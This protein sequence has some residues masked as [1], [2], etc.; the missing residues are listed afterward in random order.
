MTRSLFYTLLAVLVLA[1]PLAAC[2]SGST[3]TPDG[4]TDAADGD[5]IDGDAVDG[6]ET[7]GDLVDG[8]KPDGDVVDGDEDGDVD[9]D[10]VDGDQESEPDPDIDLGLF[11][12]ENAESELANQA[13]KRAFERNPDDPNARFGYAFSEAMVG[14]DTLF[15]LL[16][17]VE[18]QINK[19]DTKASKEGEDGEY[20]D[21]GDW[22]DKELRHA[23]VLI[24][25][26]FNRASDLYQP[27]LE[28]GGVSLHVDHLPVT[29]GVDEGTW[30]TGEIDDADVF[31][32]DGMARTMAVLFEFIA[33]H[34]IH[35]DLYG[36]VSIVK[37]QVQGESDFMSI[38]GVV[39]YLLQFDER[40]LALTEDG[41]EV[42]ARTR[43]L[44]LG[45]LNDIILAAG[46]AEAELVVDEDQSDEIFSVVTERGGVKKLVLNVSRID[47]ATGEPI[48]NAIE[49][50]TP[51]VV[52]AAA[53][54]RTHITDGGGPLSFDGP[55][56]T[57]ISSLITLPIGFGLLDWFGLDI[58]E[59]LGFDY[60]MITPDLLESLLT[61]VLKLNVVAI[62]L[63]AY[64]EAPIGLRDMLPAWTTDLGDMSNRFYI[65]WECPAELEDDGL[66][67][68]SGSL[69]CAG[70]DETLVDGPH[71]VGSDYEIIADGHT[72]GSP[73]IAL[74]DPTFGGMLYVDPK[75]LK[76]EGYP[77]EPQWQQADQL[78]ANAA[79]AKILAGIMSF[80][81]K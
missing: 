78:S 56:S 69:L 57:V 26:H 7:D 64:Y 39:V 28:T 6:D 76:L 12:L 3:D 53:D 35:T 49:I 80:V 15:L 17:A 48:T 19:V 10:A 58:K 25:S 8:D 77:E 59:A 54:M 79:L 62:D 32:F 31:I 60:D 4:D 34:Q 22:L 30:L 1:L 71:F 29:F 55:L 37:D 14:F 66:P 61:G 2:S 45:A 11:W 24:G 42:I 70:A 46:A 75:K 52:A 68:G 73:Y 51:E 21:F 72:V 9:G 41:P 74:Q 5:S 38:M 40:F 16:Q 27:L 67:D 33:A 81:G 23:M 13:F 44:M 18:G 43:E 20:A 36:V 63:H 65:E 47:S 50:V